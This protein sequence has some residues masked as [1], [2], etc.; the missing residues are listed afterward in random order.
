MLFD[1]AHATTGQTVLI[2]GAAGN[3]GAYAVQLARHAALH[4]VA[5]APTAFTLP[6]RCFSAAC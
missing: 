6:E 5:T 4:T 1:N 3:V 2:L